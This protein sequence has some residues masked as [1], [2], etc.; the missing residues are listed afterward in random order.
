MGK[1]QFEFQITG[2]H[3][4]FNKLLRGNASVSCSVCMSFGI[5]D[6]SCVVDNLKV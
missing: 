5:S 2:V 4:S 3:C 6:M 1:L